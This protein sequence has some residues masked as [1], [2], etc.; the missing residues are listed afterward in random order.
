MTDLLKCWCGNEPVREE[1]YDDDGTLS[2]CS[3]VGCQNHLG[4]G[5][6][7][8]ISLWHLRVPYEDLWS[9]EPLPGFFEVRGFLGNRIGYK[10]RAYDT[11]GYTFQDLEDAWNDRVR[12]H[13]EN[14]KVKHPDRPGWVGCECGQKI[15]RKWEY[16]PMCG[17][18]RP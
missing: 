6:R 10:K 4:R 12:K 3:Y 14:E 9:D 16:C 17:K 13:N 18:P 7:M 11:S 5:Y 15:A 1:I 8:G 2:L